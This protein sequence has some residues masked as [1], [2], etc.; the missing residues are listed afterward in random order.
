[1]KR[2]S[3]EKCSVLYNFFES[4]KKG[5]LG[6]GGFTQKRKGFENHKGYPGEVAVMVALR[7]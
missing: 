7:R 6:K 1:M 3:S 5:G 2:L 4:K